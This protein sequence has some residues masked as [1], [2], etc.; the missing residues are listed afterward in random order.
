MKLIA[1]QKYNLV[2]DWGAVTCYYIGYLKNC[3]YT[4]EHCGRELW[5]VHEFLQ[6]INSETNYEDCYNG[7]YKEVFYVG[8]TCIKKTVEVLKLEAEIA[9]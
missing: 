4:C 6:P 3:N 8:T 7:K 2:F 9:E 1:G 5:N